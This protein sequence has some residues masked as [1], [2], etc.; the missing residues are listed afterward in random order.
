[1]SDQAQQA[2]Q[3][4]QGVLHRIIAAVKAHPLYEP[5]ASVF[6]WQDLVK[7]GLIF[8]IGCFFFF[9]VIVGD[10]SVLTLTSYMA[11]TVLTVSFVYL[12]MQTMRGNENPF[13]DRLQKPDPA[14]TQALVEAHVRAIVE[15]W[16]AVKE[17]LITVFFSADIVLTVIAT[18]VLF[19][20][21]LL[22]KWFQPASL[23]FIEF[24]VLFVWPRLYSEKK[25]T[26]D[27]FVGKA[28]GAVKEKVGPILA[29]LPINK[30]KR[31]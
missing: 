12:K 17:L 1:M 21:S 3:Q 4:A 11:L 13:K 5:V 20:T 2:E 27:A 30:F 9:L 8:A 14:A 31:E 24:L 19:V 6:M 18:T 28:V 15:I 23:L 7:S 26:I 16:E 22:G 29:K 10:Y 25:D